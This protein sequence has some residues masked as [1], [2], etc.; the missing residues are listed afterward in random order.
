MDITIG[1]FAAQLERPQT[2]KFAWPILL[3]P[4]LFATRR[5]L[6]LL[7]GYFATIGWTVYLADFL[8]ANATDSPQ[9]QP[10]FAD[11]VAQVG[12]ML[13]TLGRDA[14]VAGHGAGGL[15]ALKM[16]D[17]PGI[18]AAVAF[19]PLIPRFRSPF[20]R[21][22]RNRFALWRGNPLKPPSGRTLFELVADA[23]PFHRA[24]LIE[25]LVP[26]SGI[27]A[28]EI[29]HG[30]IMFANPDTGAPRLIVAGDADIFAPH[31]RTSAF[32]ASVGAK[33]ATLE[34]RGHWIIGGRAL[35]RAVARAQRFLVRSLGAELLLLY[36]DRASEKDT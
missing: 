20:F 9:S 8:T 10:C 22:A 36:E 12:E 11:V 28:R 6:S 17:H 7:A 27:I 16:A 24:Q 18:K 21:G 29:L 32:A 34:G 23:D 3:L 31:D 25:A 30:E 26:A 15:I 13:R 1:R 19:A 33:L 2:E 14:I 5:H 35:E 4:D